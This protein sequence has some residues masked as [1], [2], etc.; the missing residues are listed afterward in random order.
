MHKPV[1]KICPCWFLIRL[2]SE[3]SEALFTYVGNHRRKLHNAYENSKVEFF[4]IQQQGSVDVLLYDEILD[5][6]V[7]NSDVS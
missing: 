7:E 1:G 2:C 3:P 6:L 5:G 4:P